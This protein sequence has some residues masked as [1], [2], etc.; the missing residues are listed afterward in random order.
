MTTIRHAIRAECAPERVWALLADLEAVQRYNPGVKAAA[1]EGS[2]RRGVGALRSCE[3]LPRGRVVERVTHWDEGRALGL[4]VA[5]SDWPI[6]SMRWVTRLEPAGDG[7]LIHQDLEYRVRFGPLGWLL[8]QI[9]MQRKLTATLD[10]VL[11][12]LVRHAEAG[13]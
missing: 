10:G 3:L 8:D 12:S 5:Q 7:T 13:R 9:V 11:A 1:I 2:Q 4:E 6:H